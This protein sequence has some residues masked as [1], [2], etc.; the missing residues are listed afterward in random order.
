MFFKLFSKD[1]TTLPQEKRQ[2]ILM[3]ALA[4]IVIATLIILYFGFRSPSP[5]TSFP[6]GPTIPQPT[7]SLLPSLENVIEKID[8]DINFLKGP[9]L[10]KLKIYGE[11][12]LKIEK[13]GRP[14]PFLP[15]YNNGQ[16]TM[17]NKQYY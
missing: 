12:P 1:S 6:V 15:Y 4:V 11:W 9:L 8:F 10:E 7:V 2:R 16:R 17:N 13:K 3:V 14:N 5:S